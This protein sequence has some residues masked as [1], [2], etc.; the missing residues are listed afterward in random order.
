MA[1]EGVKSAKKVAKKRGRKAKKVKK[2][3]KI[4]KGKQRKFSVFTGKKEKTSSGLTKDDLRKN[5][6]GKVVSKKASDRAK[7][8]YQKSGLKKWFKAVATARK[9]LKITGF[10]PVGGKTMKGQAL[11]KKVRSLYKK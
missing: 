8:V 4:A 1:T 6:D 11:L 7:K 2:V 9:T 10:T 5:A 3:S